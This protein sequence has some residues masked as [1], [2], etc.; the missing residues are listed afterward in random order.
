[1]L[2]TVESASRTLMT[3]LNDVLDHAKIESGELQIE[4]V[5]F[6]LAEVAHGTLDLFEAS[7]AEKEL[8]LVREVEGPLEVLGDPTRI[9]QIMSNFLSNAI[10][11][12]AVGS[13]RLALGFDAATGCRIEVIDSGIGIDQAT[14]AQISSRFVRPAPRPRGISAAPGW[15]FR[16]AS[17]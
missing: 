14:L 7:A 3:V 10:K 6:D 1:M 8:T 12:T 15:G 5:A 4:N 9:Q 11:F 17:V 13:V 2:K 16:S